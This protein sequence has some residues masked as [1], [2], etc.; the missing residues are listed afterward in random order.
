MNQ[1]MEGMCF[2]VKTSWMERSLRRFRE[3]MIYRITRRVAFWIDIKLGHFGVDSPEFFKAHP[4]LAKWLGGLDG[5]CHT[6]WCGHGFGYSF[7][8][9]NIYWKF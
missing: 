2:E 3:R 8:I 7:H 9:A 5:F 1:I 4:F 6:H